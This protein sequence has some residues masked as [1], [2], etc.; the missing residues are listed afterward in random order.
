MPTQKPRVTVTLNPYVYETISRMAELTG[1]SRGAIIADMIEH[2]HAPLMRTVAL[3]EAASEAPLQARQGL[4]DLVAKLEASV[5]ATAAA[6]LTQLD[7]LSEAARP[8]QPP[9]SK[10]APAPG[11]GRRS[12]GNPRSSNTGVRSPKKGKKGK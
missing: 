8:S 2:A 1:Q 9:R 12:G 7:F 6:N 11:A 4:H 3:L 10:A 5:Q